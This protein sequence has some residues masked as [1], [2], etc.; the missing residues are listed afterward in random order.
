MIQSGKFDSPIMNIKKIANNAS[1]FVIQRLI[2]FLGLVIV[3][4]GI[5]LFLSLATY[6]PEDPNFIF[7]DNTKIKNILGYQGS[8]LSD[9][10]F[11]SLGLISYLIPI[12]LIFTGIN[13]FR[14][15]E[16][17]LLIDNLFY[18]V[19]YSLVGT[20]FF[21]QFSNNAFDLYIN[22]NG[23]FVGV[24][25]NNTILNSLIILN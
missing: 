11:Q 8:F 5:L 2:E 23:G 19:I 10:F 24:Y 14:Y 12:T 21:N 3:I 16:I 4:L 17:L 6:S 7:P 22:G 1:N 18:A 13:I 9:L 25:L 15:K 20:I